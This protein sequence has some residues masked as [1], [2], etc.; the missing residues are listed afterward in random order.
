LSAV[1]GRT[2]LLSEGGEVRFISHTGQGSAHLLDYDRR[3]E[4]TS[5][6]DFREKPKDGAN[7]RQEGRVR[8]RSDRTDRPVPQTRIVLPAEHGQPG[9]G[10]MPASRRSSTCRLISSIST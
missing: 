7:P 9:E 8:L 6:A 2:E 3:A 10:W 5:C 4:T 1:S